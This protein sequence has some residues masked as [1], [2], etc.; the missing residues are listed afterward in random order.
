M[1][2]FQISFLYSNPGAMGTWCA[3][4]NDSGTRLLCHE[5]DPSQLVVYELPTRQQPTNT[6]KILLTAPDF[7]NGEVG[8]FSSC[9]AGLKDELVI[10]GSDDG[11][12]Y[13]WSL[14]SDL[15]QEHRRVD[16]P[17]KILSG[18]NNCIN[19]VC[20]SSNKSALLSSDDGGLIKLWTPGTRL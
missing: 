8:T 11:N 14:P 15:Q 16:H 5:R 6:G 7:T 18:N 19:S 3:R 4:F 13:I 9:F 17:I 2:D 20:Y 10:S 1:I 12:L